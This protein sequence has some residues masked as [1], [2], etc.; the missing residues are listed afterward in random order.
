[1]DQWVENFR[2]W[3][4]LVICSLTIFIHVSTVNSVSFKLFQLPPLITV[5]VIVMSG[6]ETIRVLEVEVD[7]PLSS[8]IS[9]VKNEGKAE[10]EVARAA[11]HPEANR[12]QDCTAVPQSTGGIGKP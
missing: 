10:E 7:A 9:D 1:M 4:L 2:Y 8:T 3:L 11:M 6:H 5:Q 12:T